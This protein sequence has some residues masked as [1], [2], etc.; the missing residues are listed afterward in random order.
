M[1]TP[2]DLF[3]TGLELPD[4][5]ACSLQQDVFEA[6]DRAPIYWAEKEMALNIKRLSCPFILHCKQCFAVC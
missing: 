2:R 4:A 3:A 1:T 6:N 5:A